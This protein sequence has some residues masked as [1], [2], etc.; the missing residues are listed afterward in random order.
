MEN[1]EF[2]SDE[3]FTELFVAATGNDSKSLKVSK[4]VCTI[5]QKFTYSQLTTLCE[6]IRQIRGSFVNVL[7]TRPELTPEHI[8]L[9]IRYGGEFDL[10]KLL[11][12]C[13]T[14]TSEHIDA[15][16]NDHTHLIRV[17]AY[18]HPMCTDAMKVAYH[19]KWGRND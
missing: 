10:E 6:N 15:C 1:Q 17:L 18:A 4:S 14:L 2:I 13:Q 19:L 11:V 12:N 8:D 7:V 5:E 16:M 9:F 3:Y